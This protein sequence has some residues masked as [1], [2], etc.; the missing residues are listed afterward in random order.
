VGRGVNDFYEE[1]GTYF[2]GNSVRGLM[3]LG[4]AIFSLFETACSFAQASMLESTFR[5]LRAILG[6]RIHLEC[7]RFL[8]TVTLKL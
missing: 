3:F 2:M 7:W 1:S 6:T 8:H 5:T 4:K